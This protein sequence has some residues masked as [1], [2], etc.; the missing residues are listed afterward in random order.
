MPDFA[1]IVLVFLPDMGD[2]CRKI[3]SYGKKS[4]T[5]RSVLFLIDAF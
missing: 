1:P 3:L 2:K 5:R 4:Q